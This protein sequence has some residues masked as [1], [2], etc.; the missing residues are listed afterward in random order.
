MKKMNLQLGGIE[1]ML[2]R[3]QMKQIVGGGY[4]PQIEGISCTLT[5]KDPEGSY[6]ISGECSSDDMAICFE[7]AKSQASSLAYSTGY[8]VGFRC[9]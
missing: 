9:V 3:E 8:E 5:I 2:S 6:N 1:Q 7:N 4:V